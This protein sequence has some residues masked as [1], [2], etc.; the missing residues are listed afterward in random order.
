MTRE[1]FEELGKKLLRMKK[2]RPILASE[3]KRLGENGDFSE[4]AE[5]QIAKGKLRSLNQKILDTGALLA[6]A[7]IIGP[8][9]ASNTVELGNT[10]FLESRGKSFSY[11]ILGS[12]ESDPRKGIISSSSPIGEAL[13]GKRLGES[14]KIK[15]SEKE[16]EYK[17]IKIE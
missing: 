4:N 6:S 9:K 7:S 17:I 1:K 3:V 5:Y 14:F 11:K 12:L 2:D 16:I 8:K 15:I 10:V 13:L